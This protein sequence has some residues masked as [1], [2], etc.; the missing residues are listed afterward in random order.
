VS[1]DTDGAGTTSTGLD[2]NPT[3]GGA[4]QYQGACGPLSPNPNYLS[5]A[6]TLA[7]A[8][9]GVVKVAPTADD[10]TNA[11]LAGLTNLSVTVTHQVT[12][13][14]PGLSISFDAE[15][16]TVTSGDPV[17]WVETANIAS[18]A[19]PG[20][21]L[22]CTVHFLLNGALPEDPAFTQTISIK[23]TG[24]TA[25]LG[26]FQAADPANV[27][28]HVIYD[29]GNG[30]KEPA[31]VAL[32]GTQVATNIVQFQ[33]NVDPSLSCANQTGSATLTIV[34]TNGVDAVPV[35]IPASSSVL[36]VADKPPSAAIYQP[37]LDAVIPYTS[38]FSLNGH[39][40]DP[41]DG[42]LTPHWAIVSGP[43]TPAVGATTDTVDVAPPTGGWPAGDY[44]V[45]LT[46]T[47]S[48]GHTST[49]TATI[50]V[51]RFTFGGF[52][53]PVD[54]P[55]VLNT[56]KAGRTYPLKFS[57]SQNGSV[58]SD[59]S[60]VVALRFAATGC[61]AQEPSD[62][63]ETTA[64]GGTQLRFDAATQRY[65]YNWKTPSEPGCYVVTLTLA[66]GSTLP[67]FFKLS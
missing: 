15:S 45:R 30:E 43:I 5:Q 24:G 25:V 44:V 10:V 53:E 13:C 32:D 48:D 17:S 55:P 66:D 38:A 40:A 20:S 34:A 23:L 35:S 65:I 60:A 1:L 37:T 9:G 8:T 47:D 11:I 46:G 49:A 14:D 57:L 21:T 28:A 42:N 54:N 62:A 4:G 59:L 22:T 63:L 64:T 61:N 3:T 27:R 6:T 52:F 58:V 39:V 16:K 29:C 41:E 36:P 12:G 2:G 31:F 33:K 67:A 26:T 50:H 56:G 7:N 19:T 18:S 51:V